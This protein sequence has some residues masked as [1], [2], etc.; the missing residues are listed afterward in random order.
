MMPIGDSITQGS[1]G[2]QT[3]RCHLDELLTTAGVAFD[4]VGGRSLPDGGGEYGCP[5]PFDTDHEGR[6][7][8]RIEEVIPDVTAAALLL[9]PDVALI[10]LG[11]NDILQGQGAADTASELATLVEELRSARSDVVVLVA[12]II[13]CEPS[14]GTMC[15]SDLPDFNAFVRELASKL[16]T[17]Q[18]PVIAVDMAT[19]F[20]L[21][22]LRDGVHPT[23]A[24]DLVLAE[25]WFEAL[26]AADLI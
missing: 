2:W 21:D 19:G 6:W 14:F 23:D 17:T 3:Y 22:D 26:N 16:S 25:R 8:R 1:A 11:T 18:S 12:Q 7:G 24:G 20:F 13:P 15:S 9:Q 10:H 5:R 4:F